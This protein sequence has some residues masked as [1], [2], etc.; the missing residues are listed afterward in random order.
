M[1]ENIPVWSLNYEVVYYIFFIVISGFR[2]NIKLLFIISF[3]TP[4]GLL[5]LSN[6]H[7]NQH[8][9]EYFIFFCFWISGA[10]IADRYRSIDWQETNFVLLM[11]CVCAFISLEYFDILHTALNKALSFIGLYSVSITSNWDS[12][13]NIVK[14]LCSLPFCIIIIMLFIGAKSRFLIYGYYFL[15]ALNALTLIYIYQH[16]HEQEIHKF[17]IPTLFFLASVLLLLWQNNQR[18]NFLLERFMQKGAAVGGISYGIYIIHFPI[19]ASFKSVHEF[20]GSG[21]TFSVRF[22]L[23]IGFSIL[24]AYL[25]EKKWQPLAVRFLR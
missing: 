7:I 19:L 25:L 20:S 22:I 1:W 24:A 10:V 14:D 16:R 5:L 21:L 2:L 8:V 15:Q 11:S 13:A 17:I 18:L 6:G 9:L 23:V 4:L 12:T 3:I